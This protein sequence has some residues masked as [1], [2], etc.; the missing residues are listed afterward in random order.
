M[1]WFVRHECGDLT[2]DRWQVGQAMLQ[3]RDRDCR[4]QRLYDQ[5][6]GLAANLWQVRFPSDFDTKGERLCGRAEVCFDRIRISARR[7]GTNRSRLDTR[8][9]IHASNTGHHRR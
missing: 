3:F 1:R 6:K 7:F 8:R 5:L 4:L 9:S 2:G